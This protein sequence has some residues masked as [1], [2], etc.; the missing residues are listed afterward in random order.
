MK[1]ILAELDLLKSLLSISIISACIINHS[2]HLA[3]ISIGILAF[4]AVDKYLTIHGIHLDN[5]DA[6]ESV[7]QK[8]AEMDA[9]LSHLVTKDTAKDIMSGLSN[10]R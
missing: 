1:R 7:D 3:I 4:I 5:K 10:K 6:F 9:K 2:Y 8:I